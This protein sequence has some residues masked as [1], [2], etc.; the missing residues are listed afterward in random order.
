MSGMRGERLQIAEEDGH[1]L[2]STPGA[3]DWPAYKLLHHAAWHEL[4]E[5]AQRVDRAALTVLQL[6]NLPDSGGLR[7]RGREIQLVN[8]V[9]VG[10]HPFNVF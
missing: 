9:E 5:G 2:N 1:A 3:I 10:R 8:R 7:R 6:G 4:G